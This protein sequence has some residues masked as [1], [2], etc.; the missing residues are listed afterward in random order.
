MSTRDCEGPC[1]QSADGHWTAFLIR[2]QGQ[3][4]LNG[5]FTPD[6]PDAP[7]ASAMSMP[8]PSWDEQQ[9]CPSKRCSSL[10]SFHFRQFPQL[11]SYSF[12]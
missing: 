4:H 1:R 3:R 5:Q 12:D 9:C 8:S 2:P 6:L 7:G 10:P 11:E